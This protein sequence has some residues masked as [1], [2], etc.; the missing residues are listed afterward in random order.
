MQIPCLLETLDRGLNLI[1][2]K[3]VFVTIKFGRGFQNL[4]FM[5][6][7]VG[8]RRSVTAFCIYKEQMF[9]M[10]DIDLKEAITA[11]DN[12]VVQYFVMKQRDLL[13][14]EWLT[15]SPQEFCTTLREPLI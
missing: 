5:R 7:S 4:R 2:T 11:E 13:V 1:V 6:L 3:I 8:L 14:K 9:N 10:D 15:K 12:D